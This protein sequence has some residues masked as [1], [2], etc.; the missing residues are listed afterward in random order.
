MRATVKQSLTVAVCYNESAR[1]GREPL[2]RI[3]T[4]NEGGRHVEAG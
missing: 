2:T 3:T 1:Q 4:S